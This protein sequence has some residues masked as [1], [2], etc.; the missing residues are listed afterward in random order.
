MQIAP[1][2]EDETACLAELRRCGIIKRQPEEAC[3][4]LTKPI[5]KKTLLAAIDRCLAPS[6]SE[7]AA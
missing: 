7:A 1:L 3:N 2:P 6:S 5:K 4:D